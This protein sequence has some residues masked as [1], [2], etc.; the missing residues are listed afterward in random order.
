[1]IT[2]NKDFSNVTKTKYRVITLK[3]KVA[4]IGEEV[5][6]FNQKKLFVSD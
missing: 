5:D 4:L 3:K 2:N 6:I 1:M